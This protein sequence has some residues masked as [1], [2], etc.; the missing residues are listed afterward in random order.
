MGERVK[1]DFLY[2]LGRLTYLIFLVL[3]LLVL[4]LFHYAAISFVFPLPL[5]PE[6]SGVGR[7]YGAVLIGAPIAVVDVLL[8][9]YVNGQILEARWIAE[10]K[11]R[12]EEKLRLEQANRR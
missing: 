4:A 9:R 5:M 2:Y 11:R 8:Y 7:V 1:E 10:N 6:F 3:V 12:H